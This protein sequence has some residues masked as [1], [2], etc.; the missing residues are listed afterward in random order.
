MPSLA[1]QEI[2]DPVTERISNR[3]FASRKELEVQ[4]GYSDDVV[5]RGHLLM[6]ATAFGERD[7]SSKPSALHYNDSSS[8]AN[9]RRDESGFVLKPREVAMEPSHDVPEDIS[10]KLTNRPNYFIPAAYVIIDAFQHLLGEEVRPQFSRMLDLRTNIE[11]LMFGHVS[12]YFEKQGRKNILGKLEVNGKDISDKLEEQYGGFSIAQRTVNRFYERLIERWKRVPDIISSGNHDYLQPEEKKYILHT[13]NHFID[14]TKNKMRSGDVLQSG[15]IESRVRHIYDG[16]QSLLSNPEN[17]ETV[18]PS[19]IL[20]WQPELVLRVEKTLY[21]RYIERMMGAIV[22]EASAYRSSNVHFKPDPIGED[23]EYP[24]LGKYS[25]ARDRAT[26]MGP[27][28]ENVLSQFRKHRII[29]TEGKKVIKDLQDLGLPNRRLLNGSNFLYEG[30]VRE[31]EK[32]LRHYKDKKASQTVLEDEYS[33]FYEM[34]RLMKDV[35]PMT[36]WG[37]KTINVL[38]EKPFFMF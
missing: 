17:L 28:L 29:L 2:N 7:Y 26:N 22:K 12:S 19:F 31:L 3:Q 27:K 21:K 13:N 8:N 32:N 23:Y 11:G 38:F 10:K 1:K 6:Y 24:G 34:N 14:T 30:L 15:D 36:R 9:V 33:F 5:S 35:K 37:Q 4:T 18:N 25:D 16:M 20:D